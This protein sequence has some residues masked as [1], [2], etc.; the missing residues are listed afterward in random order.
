M[1]LK[2]IEF[3]PKAGIVFDKGDLSAL[4]EW[5]K[6]HYD[7]KCRAAGACGGFLYGLA[8]REDLNPPGTVHTLTFREV[9]TLAKIAEGNFGLDPENK[10]PVIRKALSDVM[11]ALR[12]AK[13]ENTVVDDPNDDCIEPPDVPD[14]DNDDD[15]LPKGSW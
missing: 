7:F 12:K 8:N 13:P 2:E 5:S 6:H 3:E 15:Y 11:K 1:K 4:M 9:D 14:N 10:G